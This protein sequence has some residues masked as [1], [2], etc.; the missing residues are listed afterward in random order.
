[1][2]RWFLLWTVGGLIGLVVTVGSVFVD[3]WVGW[4]MLS[5]PAMLTA[6][7]GLAARQ[8]IGAALDAHGCLA[9]RRY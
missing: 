1:M 3:S 8:V 7:A 9:A 4:A 6:L 2:L 5:V